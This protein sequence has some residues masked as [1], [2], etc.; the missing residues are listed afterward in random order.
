M[1]SMTVVASRTSLVGWQYE[2]PKT[3]SLMLKLLAL[4]M[5]SVA[6]AYTAFF[7]LAVRWRQQHDRKFKLQRRRSDGE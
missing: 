5:I 3:A 1:T 7:V 6:L 4:I 2:G